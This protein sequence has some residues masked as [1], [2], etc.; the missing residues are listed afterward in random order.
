MI[1]ASAV[2]AQSFA[3]E[4]VVVSLR[5]RLFILGVNF[6]GSYTHDLASR[7]PRI[8]APSTPARREFLVI[9]CLCVDILNRCVGIFIFIRL[10]T[11]LSRLSVLL[12]SL[13]QDFRLAG[14]LGDRIPSS[15]LGVKTFSVYLGLNRVCETVKQHD[16]LLL[17][18]F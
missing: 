12:V 14:G 6:S 11:S 13:H 3:R 5:S 10:I 8:N 18:V 2:E 9:L 16:N 17:G 4:F 7:L 1:S 15:D